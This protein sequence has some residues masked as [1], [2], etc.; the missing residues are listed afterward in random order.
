MPSRASR[1]NILKAAATA[2]TSG[3]GCGRAARGDDPPAPMSDAG[4]KSQ[5]AA[6]NRTGSVPRRQLGATGAAVS[7][8]G[9]G[10]FHLGQAKSEKEAMQIVA[11][12]MDAGVNFFDNAWEYNDG[13]SEEWLGR[14]LLEKC[15][16]AVVMTKACTHGRD[17]TVALQQLGETLRRLGTDPLHH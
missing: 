4:E 6:G 12:A 2:A 10:G 1:R 13:R 7:I 14:A 9:L 8:I 5:K 16:L 15:A 17:R 3:A 11:E